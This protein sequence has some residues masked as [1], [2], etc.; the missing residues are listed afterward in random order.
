MA[1]I[2][3]HTYSTDVDIVFTSDDGYCFHQ[4]VT[5]TMDGIAEHVCDMFAAHKFTAADVCDARTG[6]VLMILERT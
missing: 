2:I 5:D 6:E 3:K 4:K 1:I